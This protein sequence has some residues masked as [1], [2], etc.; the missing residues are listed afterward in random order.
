M[1]EYPDQNR[2]I[3]AT[4]QAIVATIIWGNLYG[5]FKGGAMDFW[6]LL[7]N[8][9]RRKCELIVKTVIGHQSN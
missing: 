8:Q 6:D 2:N 4:P 9:D 1:S 5:D 7:S 3:N